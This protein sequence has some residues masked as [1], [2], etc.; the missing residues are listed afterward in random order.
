MLTRVIAAGSLGGV[1]GASVIGVEF[2]RLWAV[3]R[4]S[5]AV[6]DD[7]ILSSSFC[8]GVRDGLAGVAGTADSSI[9]I[10]EGRF[11]NSSQRLSLSAS[12]SAEGLSSKDIVSVTRSSLLKLNVSLQRLSSK[13]VTCGLFL[14]GESKRYV[15]HAAQ[16]ASAGRGETYSTLR[17]G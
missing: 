10:D 17:K 6:F 5:E 13:P 12:S 2:W 7:S 14:K 1:Y 15:P 9:S 8:F 3:R 11:M 16:A 4:V